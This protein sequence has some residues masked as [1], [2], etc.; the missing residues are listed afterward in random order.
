LVHRLVDHR[1]SR[2]STWVVVQS[3][4]A[5]VEG[6]GAQV[7]LAANQQTWMENSGRPEAPLEARRDLTGNQFYLIDDLTNGALMDEEF[8]ASGSPAQAA[9]FPVGPALALVAVVMV[10]GLIVAAMRSRPRKT[11]PAYPAQVEAQRGLPMAS[12]LIE[13]GAGQSI[14]IAGDLSIGRAP[15]N[16]LPIADALVSSRH[17][18]IFVQGGEYVI[19]DLSSR[20]GTLVN[21]QRVA[22]QRLRDGDQIRIGQMTFI[23]Q[24]AAGPAAAPGAP[25]PRPAG[26]P[27]AGLL[28]PQGEFVAMRDAALAIGRAS[29]NQVVLADPQASSRHARLVAE[30][31]GV[32]VEDLDSTNGTFVNGQQVSRQLLAPGDRIRVGHTE[33]VFQM[34]S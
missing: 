28:L 32:V 5:R 9:P 4:Q 7:T 13:G 34:G 19:E 17:A 1:R 11:A 18:R 25:Q 16:R 30:P 22:T 20:N 6:G 12:L 21:G 33:M 2:N 3:G 26:R 15:D 8:L 29:D 10:G 14:A 23:F 27:T 24:R 31:G